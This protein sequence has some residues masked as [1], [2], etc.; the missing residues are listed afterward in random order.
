MANYVT[1]AQV[2]NRLRRSFQPLYT[3]RGWTDE[4]EII[5]DADIE[6]AE[7]DLHSYLAGRYAVPVTDPEAVKLLRHWAL[8]LIEEIAYGAIAGT[9]VPENVA[10]RAKDIRDRLRQIADGKLSLGTATELTAPSAGPSADFISDGPAPVMTRT[11]LEG[12]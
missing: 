4:D 7:A 8:T 1:V 9:K 2:K 6:A 11:K 3:P 5:V 12:F 10:E